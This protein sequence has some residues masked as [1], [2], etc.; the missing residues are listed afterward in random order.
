MI[1]AIETVYKGYKF[2]SRLEA[3]WAVFFDSLGAPWQYETEG[4]ELERVRY[5]PD[6]W[7]PRQD[8]W[9]EIKPT[10]PTDEERKKAGLLANQS[11]KWV[12]I[13]YGDPWPDAYGILSYRSRQPSQDPTLM[14]YIDQAF[15]RRDWAIVLNLARA[16]PQYNWQTIFERIRTMGGMSPLVGM[17]LGSNELWSEQRRTLGVCSSCNRL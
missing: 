7:M 4:F 3:R 17:G 11:G 15:G 14:W 16:N 5:L 2:R 13:F 9:I 10:E 8:F 12:D 1:K 6:F